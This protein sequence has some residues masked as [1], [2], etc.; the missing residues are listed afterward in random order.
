M[1]TRT[2]L[3]VF[4]CI[5]LFITC[6]EDT[7][8]KS[9]EEVY[10]EEM[11]IEAVNY[12]DGLPSEDVDINK[13]ILPNGEY[14]LDFLSVYAPDF[15]AE[16]PNKANGEKSFLKDG[17]EPLVIG[18]QALKN[19]LIAEMQYWAHYFVNDNNFTDMLNDGKTPKQLSGLAYSYGSRVWNERKKPPHG[20]CKDEVYGLDCSGL[21]LNCA[22]RTSPKLNLS[23]C[24]VAQLSDTIKWLNALKQ[25][26]KGYDKIRVREYTNQT[27]QFSEL[28]SGDMVFYYFGG[29]SPTHMG[30]VSKNDAGTKRIFQSNGTSGDNNCAGNYA[31]NRGPRHISI[32]PLKFDGATRWKALRFE[33]DISGEWT[34]YIKCLIQPTDAIVMNFTIPVNDGG[35]FQA[36][37]SGNDYNNNNPINVFLQ[38]EY[39]KKN[40]TLSGTFTLT[41]PNNPDDMRKDRFSIKLDKDET[42][43][44]TLEK[45]TTEHTGCTIQMR[46]VN[47]NSI[48][49][50]KTASKQNVKI[51]PSAFIGEP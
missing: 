25:L 24:N 29:N 5:F 34:G 2:I 50:N 33:V 47:E 35:T 31:A 40:N 43:Y 32:D 3:T 14:L 42:P 27:I 49:K 12:L 15:L 20:A 48:S 51:D 6:K 46:L 13:I 8:N 9:D 30:I 22:W 17:G 41:F 4:L 26:G 38:G 7:D 18:P 10:P 19:T 37:G 23:D 39:D 1:K 45:V 21:V 11:P 36:F 28:E 44:F 16:F